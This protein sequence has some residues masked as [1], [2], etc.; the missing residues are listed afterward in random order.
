ME[1]RQTVAAHRFTESARRVV[2]FS[3]YEASQWGSAT[4]EP[5]H[6]L[7][8]LLRAGK[9]ALRPW[10]LDTPDAAQSVR[11]EV[12]AEFPLLRWTRR[13]TLPLSIGGQRV[14][15]Y[16]VEEAEHMGCFHIGVEHLLLGILREENSPAAA[17]LL[18]RRGLRLAE[19]R[20][21]I[22]GQN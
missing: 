4:I 8:G 22:S 7:L 1:R 11:A 10:S 5:H 2:F 16:A 20:L 9:G 21:K 19:I 14:I 15:D 17:P 12:E 3:I 6:L 18:Q 13:D